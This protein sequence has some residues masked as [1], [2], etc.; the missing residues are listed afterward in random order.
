[1]ADTTGRVALVYT[2]N[3]IEGVFKA[4]NLLKTNPVKGKVVVLKP[5]FNTADP[6]PASTHNDT[7]YGLITMLKEMGA[8]RIVIAERSGPATTAEVMK[9]KGIFDMGKGLGFEIINLDEVGPN[10]WVHTKPESSHWADGFRFARVYAEAECVVQTC[11][12]KTHRYGGHFTMSL[13]NSVGMV[14]RS[15]MSELHRS[16]YQRQMIAEINTAYSPDLIVMDG[17]EVFVSG[18]P[19]EG[20]KANAR[21]MVAG[22]D[23]VAIDI[24][25]VAVL[26]LLGTTPEVTR[27]TIFQQDQIARAVELGLGIQSPDDIQFIT[28][29][30]QSE[31][32]ATKLKSIILEN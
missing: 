11:C 17:I 3:R 12:L 26:R 4:V 10:S 7:L 21:V 29:S 14:E 8:A 32:L 15:F 19:M 24:V 2:E 1:M 27:G 5:N 6:C 23:R 31:E 18:G 9:Q 20:I 28:D 25:G 16:P 30:T 22:N 13:K